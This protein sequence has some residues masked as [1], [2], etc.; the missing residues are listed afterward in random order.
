MMRKGS[1]HSVWCL[2]MAMAC[3]SLSCSS[4][5]PKTP[6]EY[7]NANSSLLRQLSSYTDAEQREGIDRIR[8]L[9]REQGSA[10]ILYIL[11]DRSL[12]DY[13][14]QVVLGCLLAEWH[15]PAAIST[16]LAILKVDDEGA[17]ARAS[18]GLLLFADNPQLIDALGEMLHNAAPRERLIA[19]EILAKCSS[20]KTVSFFVE[21]FKGE[22]DASVRAV[23]LVGLIQSSDPRRRAFLVDALTDPDDAIRSEA[24]RALRRGDRL[25]G[26]IAYD[27][28]APLEDRAREVAKLKLWVRSRGS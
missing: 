9:G 20:A 17:V 14:V 24:W 4:N 19:A 18:D 23:Y 26:G 10:V 5:E 21:N 8:K 28:Q 3:G 25:P 16:L 22:T 1:L 13:R 12:E 7:I 2:C 6:A 15:H 27:P 11:S